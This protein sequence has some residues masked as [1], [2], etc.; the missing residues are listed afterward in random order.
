MISL[1]TPRCV[2]RRAERLVDS[3]NSIFQEQ[4]ISA[5]FIKRLCKDGSVD[6]IFTNEN[7]DLFLMLNARYGEPLKYYVR[8]GGNLLFEDSTVKIN[9]LETRDRIHS[10]FV[11]DS[12]IA[13]LRQVFN[14][15]SV[16]I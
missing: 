1:I 8:V 11:K 5:N 6:V 16:I 14:T 9:D 4:Q 7:Y 10:F 3:F 13:T 12:S 15:K 2:E